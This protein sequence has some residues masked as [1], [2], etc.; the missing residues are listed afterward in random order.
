MLNPS[1]LRQGSF[2]GIKCLT[3]DIIGTVFDVY[4]SLSVRLKP[5]ARQYSLKIDVQAY[6]GEWVNGY[7]NAVS[8]INSGAKPWTAPDNILKNA[9]AALLAVMMNPTIGQPSTSRLN[10]T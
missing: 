8:A 1:S 2:K 7:A 4:R 9:F 10:S 6:A 5:L 3:F